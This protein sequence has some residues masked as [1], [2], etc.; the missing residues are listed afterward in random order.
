LSGRPTE[1]HSFGQAIGGEE[2]IVPDLALGPLR[3]QDHA[4]L[5]TDLSSTASALQMSR[6]DG[7]VGIDVL[8]RSNFAIDYAQK[9]LHFN[10]ARS[11]PNR[12]RLVP[13]PILLVVAARIDKKALHLIVDSGASHLA[14]FG[15]PDDNSSSLSNGAKPV[16]LAG[17]AD[18]RAII[19][20]RIE[21]GSWFAVGIPAVLMDAA[22]R[23]KT[24]TD[25]LLGLPALRASF[26]QFDFQA[27]EIAWN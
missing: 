19:L 10:A 13:H 22:S 15:F 16:H 12:A 8:R 9:I 21:V 24:G 18:V 20:R 26:I 27:Q 4:V 6:L 11:L 1:L 23:G 25:G 2:L 7:I 5:A 3:V 14:L 17:R